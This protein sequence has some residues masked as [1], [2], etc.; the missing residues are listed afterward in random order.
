MASIETTP[1]FVQSVYD[2]TRERLAVIRERLNR[3]LTLAE[4]VLF[5]HLADANEELDRGKA[6]LQLRPDRVAMQDATAQMALLQFML[7]GRDTTAVPSTVH[8]DHLILARSG[9]DEDVEAAIERNREVYDFL[10]SASA[11]YG[12]GFWKPGSGIIHQVVLE[13]YAFPG[14][15]MIGTDSHTPNAGGLGMIAV[16]VG[17]ADAVD[18]MAGFN[19]EVLQPEIVGVKLTGSLEGWASPKDVIL[20]LLGILTVKGG[21]NRIIEYFGPGTES[22]S[23]TGKGTITNMGAELGAT[24]S[25]FPYDSR[26][27]IYLDATQRA[28]IA[29]LAEANKDLLTADPEVAEDPKNYFDL[30]IEIDLDTLEPHIVGP[31][32]PDLARPVSEMAADVAKHGYPENLTAG[33]IGSCTN[34]SYEDLTRAADIAQQALD[35]GAQTK[36]ALW[37]TPGSEQIEATIERDGQMATLDRLGATVLAN[38]CGPCIGQWHRDDISDGEVNSIISSFN[39]NFAKRNDGNPQTNSFIS[40]PEIVVAYALVGN[41]TSNPLTD[42]L[43]TLDGSSFRLRP[44]APAP[45]VPK[46]GFVFKAEG[47]LAPPEDRSSLEVRV[48]EGSERLQLLEPFPAWDGKD[49]EKMPVLLKAR[50]KCTT[51]H[52]SQAGPW[53]RFRGHLDNISD[54]LFLGAVNFFADDPGYGIDIETGEAV[55]LPK[56]ARSY[57]E[58]GIRWVAVG[59]ENYGEGSSRE[60]AAMEPR[61]MAGMAIIARSFA[62]IAETNLKKQGMLPLRFADPADYEKILVDD[63]LSLTGLAD[64]APGKPI[65]AVLHHADGSEESIP[66]EHSLNDEQVEWFKAGSALNVLRAKD[67]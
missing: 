12:I 20:K 54:N 51:D 52:I 56:L 38:A 50:G 66:L 48:R 37:V 23:T 4:K 47:Y 35:A 21:T 3:P 26:A 62:R 55:Q 42:E 67:L 29:T 15:M 6:Y 5:G 46:D 53:L 25:I 43:M 61:H 11:R 8:C 49:Y 24:T 59:D 58:R 17:G 60:H 27:K 10:Q 44:P 2:T 41:L 33:L 16:G 45:E 19:W 14:G 18:V 32:S 63:R 31:F 64:I 22:I 34:S 65:T 57:K 1:E 13:N 7:S 30:V 39:R 40:S 28:R 36:T 9:A